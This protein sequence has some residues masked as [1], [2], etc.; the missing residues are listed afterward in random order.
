MAKTGAERRVSPRVPVDL[1]VEEPGAEG[2][3]LR[4]S[5]NLSRGGIFLEHA[6]P[7]PVGSELDLRFSLPGDTGG[8]IAVRGR[9]VSHFGPDGF[10]MGVSFMNPDADTILRIERYLSGAAVAKEQAS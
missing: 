4:R 9:I 7:L 10:G 3:T 1:W 8:E 2:N 5:A 6:V